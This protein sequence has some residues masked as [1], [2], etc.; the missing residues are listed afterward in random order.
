[1]LND[2]NVPV[3]SVYNKENKAYGKETTYTIAPVILWDSSRVWKIL[4]AYVYTGAMVLGKT[5]T[6]ISGK[7]IVRT[8]PRGQQFITEGTHEA[9]VSREEFEKAQ[10]VIKS[11]SHKVLI[12]S[13]DFPLKGKVRCGNCRRVMTH[14]FKQVVPTFWCREGLELVGQTRCTSEIFQVSDIESAVFQAL[15]KEL[16]LLDSLYGDIQKEEQDLKEAHKKANRRKTL[17]E[18]ELKNLKG[19]KMRMYEE[20]AAGT[21]PLDTYKQKKQECD[22]RISEVEEKIELEKGVESTRSAVPGTVRA[23]AEQAENFL[24]GTRLTAGMVSAFIENVFVH[25]GG[26]IV[27]RFKYEQSIQDTVKA[28]QTG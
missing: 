27:V 9:I 1:M 20:Y 19:E 21:L 25:D 8:V 14:N 4:T 2:E 18:Q 16:S 28:L 10:L 17:M 22:R 26:R 5:K 3:P 7:S 6:L 15:K 24:H 13:V 12:G 11:N 23:A